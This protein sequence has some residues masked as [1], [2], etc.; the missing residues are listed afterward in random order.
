MVCLGLE[1]WAPGWSVQ[2]TPLSYGGT[3]NEVYIS[4]LNLFKPHSQ[5]SGFYRVTRLMD[6]HLRQQHAGLQ[7]AVSQP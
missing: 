6:P 3:P 7:H 2:T 4:R 5:P 1:P